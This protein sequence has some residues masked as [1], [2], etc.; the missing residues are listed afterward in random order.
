MNIQDIVSKFKQAQANK[1]IPDATA[2]LKDFRI[3]AG[4]EQAPE[5]KP[6]P[7]AKR[8]MSQPTQESSFNQ[9]DWS[10]IVSE[11][12]KQIKES[13]NNEKAIKTILDSPVLQGFGDEFEALV[14]SLAAEVASGNLPQEEAELEIKDFLKE[15]YTNGDMNTKEGTGVKTTATGATQAVPTATELR[16][17]KMEE[18]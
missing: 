7:F 2:I 15:K 1:P 16:N 4:L 17:K 12:S 9:A 18:S 11:E 13:S 3:R 14:I 5:P 8:A 10:P 6:D